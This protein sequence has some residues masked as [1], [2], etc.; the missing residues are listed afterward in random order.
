MYIVKELRILAKNNG[1]KR[2]SRLG[3]DELTKY[4]IYEGVLDGKDFIDSQQR[5]NESEPSTVEDEEDHVGI[6]PVEH[7]FDKGYRRFRIAG[8]DVNIERYF[9]LTK[10]DIKGL[11]R[12]Q[13]VD[14]GSA[15][16]QLTLWV[17]WI[18]DGDVDLF[19]DKAFNSKQTEVFHGS[20]LYEVVGVMSTHVK[21]QVE[22]PALPRSGF[23]V[24][25]IIY[26][27][28]DFHKLILTRGSSYIVLPK[29]I[30]R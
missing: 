12:V 16:I 19:V 5:T 9:E 3:K 2:Y 30:A 20:N 28:V 29:W 25:G 17:R 13:L 7:A 18:I 24:Y 22:N 1:L 23:S 6:E 10:G 26:L 4:L 21:G 11:I 14:L 8:A 15:K 27:D